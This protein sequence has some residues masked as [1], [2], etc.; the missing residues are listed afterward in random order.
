MSDNQDT[1]PG[2]AET[3]AEKDLAEHERPEVGLIADEDL[4]EDLQPTDDN[5]LA[6][7]PDDAA[8]DGASGAGPLGGGADGMPDVG[9]PGA[10]A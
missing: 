10:P 2:R 7:N 1:G 9:N 8:D 5:P 6:K 3:D 4:P